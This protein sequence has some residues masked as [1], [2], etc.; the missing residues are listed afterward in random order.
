VP[1]KAPQINAVS[2]VSGTTYVLSQT[3]TFEADTY[4]IEDGVPPDDHITWTSDLDGVLGT[5]AL[6]QIDTLSLG[7]HTITV[8]V[9]DN[10][11]VVTTSTFVVIVG[12]EEETGSISPDIFLPLIMK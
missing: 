5:G 6:L 10:Q 8:S 3:I 11:N 2:P 1:N 9:H 7:T 12:P 4:D